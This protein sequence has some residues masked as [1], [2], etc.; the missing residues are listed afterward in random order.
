MTSAVLDRRVVGVVGLGAM[1]SRLAERLFPAGYEVH[2]FNR[3]PGRAPWLDELGMK[4]DDSPRELATTSD[5]IVM[6]LW[7]SDA[8][9]GTV[10]GDDGIL[11]GARPGTII[12][13]L[14]TIEPSA[15][16][17][18]AA[19][20]KSRGVDY[21]DCPV[22][23]SLD[24]AESGELLVMAGGDP[25]VLELVLPVL[26]MLA[27]R[28]IHV[29]N[30]NGSGLALKLAIN[31]QVATQLVGWGE[32]IALTD[33]FGI[34]RSLASTIML[35]SVI[36]SPMLHYRV[37]FSFE[38]PDE[39]WASAA[40]LRKDVAYAQEITSDRARSSAIALELLDAVLADGR[41]DLE[42]V[43]LLAEA[44]DRA[45][46]GAGAGVDQRTLEWVSP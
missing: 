45:G 10:L 44:R 24:R 6:M 7:D 37:P 36:A 27:R 38:P 31:Q 30:R 34:D 22:S 2:G 17:E 19:V 13:D 32:A 11:A 25:R 41:G 40:Q 46:A 1:G 18:I 4:R 28:I 3:T 21:L 12:V 20:A 29:G 23:G 43:E 35:D 9:R 16:A 33:R 42:A 15:S 26:G 8:V 5:I 14:S 39:V